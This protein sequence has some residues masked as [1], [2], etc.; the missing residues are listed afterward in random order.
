MQVFILLQYKSHS[1]T[2][3][4]I[5]STAKKMADKFENGQQ[6]ESYGPSGN[7]CEGKSNEIATGSKFSQQVSSI[8]NYVKSPRMFLLK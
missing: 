8:A 7:N 1:Y 4:E 6:D 3:E 5:I 2:A